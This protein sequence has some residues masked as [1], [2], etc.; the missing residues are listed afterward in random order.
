MKSAN[1]IHDEAA[2]EAALEQRYQDFLASTKILN[3]NDAVSANES[4]LHNIYQQ[5]RAIHKS[6]KDVD[7]DAARA[8]I[9]ALDKLDCSAD[10]TQTQVLREIG[11][12]G[13]LTQGKDFIEPLK[14]LITLSAFLHAAN[15]LNSKNA[16]DVINEHSIIRGRIVDTLLPKPGVR[17]DMP[18]VNDYQKFISYLSLVFIYLKDNHKERQYIKNKF[19]KFNRIGNTLQNDTFMVIRSLLKMN[20]PVDPTVASSGIT[21]GTIISSDKA[22]QIVI[23]LALM[24]NSQTC[25]ELL[26]DILLD[27]R[28]QCSDAM[29]LLLGH[30]FKDA[31]TD[32]L[33][34]LDTTH[35]P[36][37]AAHETGLQ[38][39]KTE[40][41]QP[42]VATNLTQSLSKI[43][44]LRRDNIQETEQLQ[45]TTTNS[46]KKLT[47]SNMLS[48]FSQLSATL[49]CKDSKAPQT[50]K[51]SKVIHPL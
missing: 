26:V 4:T 3:G 31:I 17:Q 21:A 19:Y 10:D 45:F 22:D 2:K 11:H 29:I 44:C 7:Q 32:Y 42:V 43:I 24:G 16:E 39:I 5:F 51:D 13:S 37:P 8:A 46:S 49:W 12:L 15:K 20:E 40:I 35:K 1:A 47:R 30:Y 48:Y 28:Y 27:R 6:H 14:T 34:M 41:K 38:L 25:M 18:M 33:V 9:E 36:K 23:L 50:E